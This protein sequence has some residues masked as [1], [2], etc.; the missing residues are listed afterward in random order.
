VQVNAENGDVVSAGDVI[1]T[2]KSDE[3]ESQRDSL[4]S[5]LDELDMSIGTLRS[6]GGS[7][8]VKSPVEGT[9][10]AVYAKDGDNVDAVMDKYGALAVVS[11]DDLL[12]VTVPYK[13]NIIQGQ[14]LIVTSGSKSVTGK[15]ASIDYAASDMTVTFDKGDLIAGEK[16]TV[17]DAGGKDLGETVIE[18]A[19]PVYITGKGGVVDKVYESA[20]SDV[21]RG[22]NLFHLDGDVLS[23]TLYDNIEQREQTADDLADTK[24]K[25]E[26]LTVKAGTDGVISGLQLNPDQIVQA[27]AKLFAVKSNKHQDIGDIGLANGMQKALARI[28]GNLT[29]WCAECFQ[30]SAHHHT[31][32]KLAEQF[33]AAGARTDMPIRLQVQVARGVGVRPFEQRIEIVGRHEL[34]LLEAVAWS[35]GA[36]GMT[37]SACKSIYGVWGSIR[38]RWLRPSPWHLV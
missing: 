12:E 27:G 15:V 10:M 3:L 13:E 7:D 33:R 14:Q 30:L 9:V 22:G 8:T 38:Q 23:P 35:P 28:H 19:S 11:P 20:G 2:F 25:L 32:I 16:A 37:G 18:V 34:G 21:S 5:K 29:H 17:T 31:P 36:A 4:Q 24:A 1:A 26:S 6:T